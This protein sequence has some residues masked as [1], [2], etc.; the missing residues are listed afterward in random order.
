MVR[1]N[2]DNLEYSYLGSTENVLQDVNLEFYNNDIVSIEGDNGSGKTTFLKILAGILSISNKKIYIN[3]DEVGSI[4]YKSNIAYIPASPIVFNSLTGIEHMELI[5]DLWELKGDVKLQYEKRFSHL[6]D[7]FEMERFMD[8][9]V[10]NYSLGTKYKLYFIGM[11]SRN[12]KVILM[13]EPLTSLDLKSQDRAI[14]IIRELSK[15]TIIIFSSHQSE[16]VSKMS[17]ERYQILNKKII[18]KLKD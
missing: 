11:I 7:M 17:T 8:E 13:D 4:G 3:E 1:L 6:V 16:I 12:P 2:I 10:E 15:N 9:K 14:D 5:A 18:K